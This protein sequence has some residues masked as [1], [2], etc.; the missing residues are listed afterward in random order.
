MRASERKRGGDGGSEREDG[1]LSWSLPCCERGTGLVLMPLVVD[2]TD[3]SEQ[4]GHVHMA[5]H[6]YWLLF[7]SFGKTSGL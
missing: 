6:T 3:L 1:L 5:P 4:G 7:M 2:F